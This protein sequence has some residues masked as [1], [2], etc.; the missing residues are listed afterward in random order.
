MLQPNKSTF[1]EAERAKQYKNA[2]KSGVCIGVSY[3][4]HQGKS[5]IQDLRRRRIESSVELRKQRRNDEMMKRRNIQP[6]SNESD[7]TLTD[8]EDVIMQTV[9]EKICSIEDVIA[10]ITKSPTIEQLRVVS[11]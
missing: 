3:F 2:G 4:K 10:I 8:N 5:L 7:G 6:E 1:D 11:L 9:G